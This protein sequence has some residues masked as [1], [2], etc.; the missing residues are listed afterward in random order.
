MVMGFVPMAQL[1][2]NDLQELSYYLTGTGGKAKLNIQNAFFN[3][4]LRDPGGKSNHL[5][6]V[7]RILAQNSDVADNDYI[8]FFNPQISTGG[9][10]IV[11]TCNPW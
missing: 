3:T 2:A 10:Q 4:Y 8:D 1:Y 9:T 7:G 5:L 11:I 6:N